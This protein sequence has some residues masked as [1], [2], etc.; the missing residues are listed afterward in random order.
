MNGCLPY[1][2]EKQPSIPL[3]NLGR[4]WTF[5]MMSDDD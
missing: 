2:V 3:N 1:D 4:K 5:K